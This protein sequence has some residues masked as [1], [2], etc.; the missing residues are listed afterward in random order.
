MDYKTQRIIE[1]LN[2]GKS[3]TEIQLQLSVSP[4]K[5][6]SVKQEYATHLHPQKMFFKNSSNSDSSS[7]SSTATTALQANDIAELTAEINRY[8]N[9]IKQ[10]SIDSTTLL[11]LKKLELEHRQ[12]IKQ[13][14]LD[15]KEKERR[16]EKEKRDAEIYENKLKLDRAEAIRKAQEYEIQQKIELVREKFDKDFEEF[17]QF[18]LDN[19]EE[20]WTDQ[21][22]KLCLKE[23]KQLKQRFQDICVTVGDEVGEFNE[24]DILIESEEYLTNLKANLDQQVFFTSI[25][26]SLPENLKR[27]LDDYE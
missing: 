25:T 8:K 22:F 24:W 19:N 13:M 1:M 4:S 2:E 16:F 5:I 3:Y 27:M 7:G 23:V 21:Y 15:E 17:I 6:S 11:E 10:G 18:L 12:K 26:F 9:I 20:S 14:E